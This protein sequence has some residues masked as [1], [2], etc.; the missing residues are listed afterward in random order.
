MACGLLVIAMLAGCAPT[1]P[2]N[3]Q[4]D[5]LA[6]GAVGVSYSQ[7]L[8]VDGQSPHR[9][10]VTSGALPAGL[11][12]GSTDGVIRGTPTAAGT[13]S[14]TVTVADASFPSRT[15]AQSYTLTIHPELTV[16]T[17]LPAGRVEQVYSHTFA[18]TGGVEPYTLELIG[19]P[20]G[21]SFDAS[22][23]A[24]TGTPVAA[25]DGI[26][27]QLTVTDS[28]TP[29]Q[30]VVEL[31]TLVI[32]AKAVQ[33]T[34]TQLPD[35]TVGVSYSAT[36]ETEGGDQPFSWAVTS[37]VLPEGLR[38]NLDTGVISGRP[39]AAG[40]WTFQIEVTDDDDP[41]TTDTATLT[42]EVDGG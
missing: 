8:T 14:I 21:L 24:I 5:T 26:T 37:G 34:T 32:K 12:L 17:A 25:N 22:T 6:D 30:Q 3:L 13:F 9:W 2:L 10:A 20:G 41:P 36:L 11:T 29:A 15:G 4:T 23:G 33:I 16:G 38:L 31:L 1:E 27:L 40:S 18:V 19:L 28:G 42:I 39:T 7:A 35:G